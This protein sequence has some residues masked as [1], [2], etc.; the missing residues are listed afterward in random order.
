[1][2]KIKT[3]ILDALDYL[4]Q[5]PTISITEASQLFRID[6]HTLADYHNNKLNHNNLFIS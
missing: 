3:Q 6:R 1:M 5:N 2:K 4:E